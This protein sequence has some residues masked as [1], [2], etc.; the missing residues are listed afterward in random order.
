MPGKP[1]SA[2]MSPSI[3]CRLPQH[4]A[5]LFSGE[6]AGGFLHN[7]LTCDVNAVP[8]ERCT[9]GGLCTPKGRL[10]A[11]FL[12]WRTHQGYIMQLPAALREA[13]Q[14]RL[15]LYILRSRVKASDLSSTEAR[16][17]LTGSGAESTLQSLFGA[18]P[19]A[20]GTVVHATGAT[21][22]RLQAD[23]Y[24]ITV[25]IA[26]AEACHNSLRAV[27]VEAD[28]SH[29]DWLDV[30]AGVPVILPPTQ[31]EFVP[32]MVNL[33]CI[34]AVSF[35]KGCYPGQEIV[36]RMHY[37]GRLKQRMYL[38]HVDSKAPPQA[39]DR[40]YSS[41]FGDQSTGMIVNAAPAPGGGH[42]VLAVT[43]I[44]SVAAGKVHWKGLDQPELAFQS[45]PYQL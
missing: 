9:Y 44:T 11:T 30:R 37:L 7:L 17:G 10:L 36:A 5:I 39:G 35:T 29:W 14:K 3:F 40:L 26:G 20:S 28:P 25:P 18:A 38:A 22:L 31:D 27:A 45:L 41:E 13:V 34:G 23:R 2:I 12:L 19:P 4:H 32:Q 24:E 33:D 8:L 42:D 43:H 1:G 15:S 21:L 16:F 6:D